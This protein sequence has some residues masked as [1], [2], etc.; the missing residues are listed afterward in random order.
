M[1]NCIERRFGSSVVVLPVIHVSGVDQAV[2]Q[3]R[4]AFQAGAM[5]V[6]MIHHDNNDTMTLRAANEA[7]H[8]LFEDGY[9]RPWIGVNMLGTKQPSKV[10]DQLN[11][12]LLLSVSG[13]W[14]D[15][16]GDQ[17]V[18]HPGNKGVWSGLWL[19][20]VAF[21]GQPQPSDLEAECLRALS[22]GVDVLTT[23]GEATGKPCDPAKVARIRA[24][25]TATTWASSWRR[26]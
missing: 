9:E 4:I 1:S 11:E 23:S 24:A 17:L 12:R 5:G 18:K 15:Q 16:I 7:Y 2:G 8:V 21:K 19:G 10:Y 13:V 25:S 20:G 26:A 14:S 22:L 6:L 3:A